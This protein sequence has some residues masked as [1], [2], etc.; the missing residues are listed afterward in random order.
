MEKPIRDKR[1]CRPT[2]RKTSISLHYLEKIL[3]ELE[4]KEKKELVKLA[5]KMILY[6]PDAL[7]VLGVKG[8]ERE[9]EDAEYD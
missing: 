7:S 4:K 6:A 8:F 3:N 5:K 1:I 2:Q 9:D